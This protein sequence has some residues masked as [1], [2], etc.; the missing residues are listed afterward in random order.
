MHT[1]RGCET[2]RS[3]LTA[4]GAG[5]IVIIASASA[6]ELRW[7]PASYSA[8]KAALI[9][10]SRQLSQCVAGRG[11]RLNSV[12]PGPFLYENEYG[13]PSI[14]RDGIFLRDLPTTNAWEALVSWS[15]SLSSSPAQRREFCWGPILLPITALPNT[16]SSDPQ[17]AGPQFDSVY[18]LMS[19]AGRWVPRPLMRLNPRCVSVCRHRHPRLS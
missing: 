17:H 16:S 13:R 4:S 11:I 18:K 14:T 12:S 8:F 6:L 9:T 15:G 19:E 7:E 2:S 5:S 1:V 10:H 3:S